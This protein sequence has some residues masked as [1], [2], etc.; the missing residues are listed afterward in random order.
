[1]KK[2]DFKELKDKII[3]GKKLLKDN[4]NIVT[5]LSKLKNYNNPE[6]D[7]HISYELISR[8]IILE[9]GPKKQNIQM[10]YLITC[11]II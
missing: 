11:K 7:N 2:K 1:M 4:K 9:V 3:I 8:K 5:N 6:L 10:N